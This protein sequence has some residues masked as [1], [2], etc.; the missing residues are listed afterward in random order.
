MPSPNGQIQDALKVSRL[1]KHTELGV[2]S[3]KN[4]IYWGSNKELWIIEENY[5]LI[6]INNV[7]KHISVWLQD[8]PR[9]TSYDFYIS[10]ILYRDVNTNRMHIRPIQLRHRHPSEY[11]AIPSSPPLRDM[12][13]FKFMIDIYND[14][15]GTYHNVYHSLGGIYIQIGNM[16]FNL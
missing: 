13:V 16:P 8:L 2:Y 14:D 10:E 3:S 15:F 5:Q 6:S 12:K 4:R 9:P 1:L 11:V 7:I